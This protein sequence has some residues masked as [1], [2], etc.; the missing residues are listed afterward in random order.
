MK[1]A[2]RAVLKVIVNM[3]SEARAFPPF[4]RYMSTPEMSVNREHHADISISGN[5]L[6]HFSP[7][8]G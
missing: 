6:F 5:T 2:V 8:L 1:L 4:V 7:L 3:S